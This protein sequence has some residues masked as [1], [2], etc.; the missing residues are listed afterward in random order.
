MST[1]EHFQRTPEQLALAAERKR[2]KAIKKANAANATARVVDD[3][4]L[5][6]PR[7]WLNLRDLSAERPT[8]GQSVRVM[9]WN[10]LAQCLIRREMFPASDCLKANQ[11]EKMTISEMM[12]Y[13]AE[14]CCMQEVD[15][16]DKLLPV[17]EKAGYG[18]V[19]ASGPRKKHGCLIAYAKGLYEP[20]RERVI[21][22]DEQD[23]R[24]E[25]PEK[26]RRGSSFWTK[27]IASLVALR[28]L[29]SDNEGLIVATTHLFWHPSQTAIL[30]REAIKFR[31]ESASSSNWPCIIA[32]DF[33][34]QPDDPAYSLLVGDPLLLAQEARLVASRVVHNSIDPDI[35]VSSAKASADEEDGGQ[36]EENDSDKVITNA[37]AATPED[38]L[39]TTVEL[40]KLFWR[41]PL[42]VSVYDLGQRCVPEDATANLTFGSRIPI[43]ALRHGAFEPI[44]T[45][46]THFWKSVLDYIFV[47]DP[48]GRRVSVNELARPHR[49]EDL[50]VGLPMKHI[51]G[52][53]HISLGAQLH[54]P[55]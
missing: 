46:Y 30:F 4:P 32:G 45:S 16:L 26:A 25:G 11:R 42:P 12:W 24:E 37:R 38:G 21:R 18:W 52:S 41:D 54:W 27:N 2:E 13:N 34:Y 5:I 7:T 23:V 28:R 20:V 8:I 43:L 17:L 15:R 6:L 14:I 10:L 9:T 29:G 33:N 47:V 49:T 44:W 19:Y 31:D 40:V 35:L 1:S 36:T 48:P 50:G 3:G 51:C 22:Y 39:L 55:R 53:D